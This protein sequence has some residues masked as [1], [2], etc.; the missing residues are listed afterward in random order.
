VNGGLGIAAGLA[1]AIAVAWLALATALA[2]GRGG[3]P[4]GREALR[5]GPDLVRLL[6]RLARDPA[7]PRR[8]RIVLA[9]LLA[10]LATPID[11]VPDVVPVIGY[12]DDAIVAAVAVR[13]ALRHA[14]PETV[15]RHWP[16]TPAGLDALFRLLRLV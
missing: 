13:V 7:V 10:Y 6:A 2:V 1:A 16:G 11:L 12:A 5:L 3:A 4:V 15:R 14:G 9:L 8:A